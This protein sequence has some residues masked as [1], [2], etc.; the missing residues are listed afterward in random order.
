ME[1]TKLNKIGLDARNFILQNK[2]PEKQIARI[3]KMIYE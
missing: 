3:I 2:T 1:R